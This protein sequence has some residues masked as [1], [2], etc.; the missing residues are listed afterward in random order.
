LKG[1]AR[2]VWPQMVAELV[3]REIYDTDTREQLAAFCT[4]MARWLDAEDD[5]EARGTLI[6]VTKTIGR[7]GYEKQI[8]APEANPSIY[9]SDKAC[10][11]M[12]KLAGEL[13]LNPV[14]RRRVAKVK[15]QNAA[16]V[17]AAKWLKPVA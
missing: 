11:R 10:D 3:S 15:Q 16:Q 6:Q 9:I 4:Q 7:K 12:Q 2:E 1:R 8:T 5:I 17:A 14:A 13:G